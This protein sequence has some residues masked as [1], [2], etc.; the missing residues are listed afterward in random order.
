MTYSDDL[1]GHAAYTWLSPFIQFPVHYIRGYRNCF[2]GS[3]TSPAREYSDTWKWGSRTIA[4]L[5]L[6]EF[7]IRQS[8]PWLCLASLTFMVSFCITVPDQM[9]SWPS[10]SLPLPTRIQL[11]WPCI[12]PCLIWTNSRSLSKTTK[13]YSPSE[14]STFLFNA[15]CGTKKSFSFLTPPTK[16][17]GLRLNLSICVERSDLNDT[18]GYFQAF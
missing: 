9:L 16:L 7:K 12:R 3:S 2:E 11:W 18:L 15:Q 13:K 17:G 14:R 10:L 6:L 1:I 4:N 5:D 8:V